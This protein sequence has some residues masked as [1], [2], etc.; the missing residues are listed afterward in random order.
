MIHPILDATKRIRLVYDPDG[1]AREIRQW[2][3]ITLW[4]VV[5][6]VVI[7]MVAV[8]HL[9]LWVEWLIRL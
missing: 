7:G 3:S 5:L 1:E 4:L 6:T 2:E 9:R 8:V